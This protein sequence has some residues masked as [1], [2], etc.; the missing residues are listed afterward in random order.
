M[1]LHKPLKFSRGKNEFFSTV[2]KRVNNYFKE[3]QISKHANAKMIFKTIILLAGYI[4][5][6]VL[7]L[8]YNFPPVLALSLWF[9]MG[10]AKA[11]IGM[12][13]MHDANHGAYSAD[14]NV[15]KV[16]GWTLNLLGGAVLNWKLQHNVL[17][18]T[19]TN[20]THHD[21]D[22][23]AKGGLRFTPHTELKSNHQWQYIY[24]F[25]LYAAT[26]LYWV[27]A[28]DFIQFNRY[29]KN[30]VYK[31][32]KS[33]IIRDTIKIILIKI[34]YFSTFFVL[35]IFI[36][37][38]TA[39]VVLLGFVIMHFVAGFILT[40]VF[41]LAHTVDETS[42]PLPDEHG[43]IDNNWAIHQMNTTVNFSRKNK[44]ISWYVG[45]LNFQVEHHLF[46]T[47]C[48]V[49]YPKI[50]EIVKKTAEEFNVPYLENLTLGDALKSHV[51]ALK[52]FGN[53]TTLDEAIV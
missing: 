14:Q 11:G 43:N 25:F 38:S 24:A 20:I 28:K 52:K 46:P 44:M 39:W 49:H 6:F 53:I 16:I 10:I 36:M 27:L 5:P 3:S 40:V 35:P 12:S 19:Y 4:L 45:G 41:Q 34:G 9:L 42:H 26:T 32:D 1:Q 29:T 33:D 17:H 48:H 2:T 47:I 15:N 18:H 50:A 51:A 8:F 13:V 31:G 30:G 22:I 7:M 23:D 21:E 37:G